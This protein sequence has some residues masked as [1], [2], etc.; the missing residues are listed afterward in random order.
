MGLFFSCF[1]L[2]VMLTISMSPASPLHNAGWDLS[3]D[4]LHDS[5]STL[6]ASDRGPGHM[7]HGGP[8]G[9]NRAP[10]G[11][12]NPALTGPDMSNVD[13][14]NQGRPLDTVRVPRRCCSVFPCEIQ[15]VGHTAARA[16]CA[17]MSG[18]AKTAPLDSKGLMLRWMKIF[19]LAF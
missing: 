15:D 13:E 6:S 8:P 10:G 14:N 16:H 4:G 3:N 2:T 19:S 1:T 12:P 7:H 11:G 17:G 9:A 18:S 5:N